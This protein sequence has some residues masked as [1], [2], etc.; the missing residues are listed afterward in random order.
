M[1]SRLENGEWA[2]PFDPRGM[3]HSKRWR[4]YTESNSWETTFAIQHDLKGYIELFG[5]R[6][7]FLEKLDTLFHQSSELPPDAPPDIAGLVGQYAHGNEPC[8]HIAYLYAYAGAPYKTQERVRQ[9]LETMYDNQP[10][11]LAGNEDCGQRSEERRVGKECRSR[12]SP[13]H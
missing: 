2:E 8:H 10:D 13:Y 5:G 9:L 1:R 11:G 6:Q 12:W 3:G 4:D 7:A